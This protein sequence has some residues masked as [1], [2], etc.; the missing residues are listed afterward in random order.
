MTLTLLEPLSL[1]DL[2]EQEARWTLWYLATKFEVAPPALRWRMKALRPRYNP[3]QALITIGPY[4]QPDVESGLL[5]EFAHHLSWLRHGRR[6]HH[7]APYWRILE[8]VTRVY[9]GHPA[10]YPWGLEYK[11]GQ[12]YVERHWQVDWQPAVARGQRPRLC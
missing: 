3:E 8:E 2:T 12:R 7:Q 1:G 4:C 6:V 9:Y 10:H 5:H 11:R